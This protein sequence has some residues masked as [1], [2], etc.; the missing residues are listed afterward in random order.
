MRTSCVVGFAFLLVGAS[1]AFAASPQVPLPPMPPHRAPGPQTAA[2]EPAPSPV[3]PA[4]A[5][6][7]GLVAAITLADIGFG[8]G[9][10]FAN[11]GGHRELFVPLPQQANVAASELVLDLDD[12]SAH[13][14][15]RNLEVQVNDRTVTA[16]V[17]DGKTRGRI[18]R[19]P[20]GRTKPKDGYLKLT[21]LYS[22]AATLD[23]C[24]DVRYVGDSLTIRPDT[25]VNVDLGTQAALDVATTA[26]LMP[27]DVAIVLPSR[28]VTASEMA[29]SV[30]VARAL[31]SS[32][33]HVTF[34]HGL[35]AVTDLAK[36]SVPG[37]WTQGIVLVGPLADTVSV[38]DA[39]PTKVAGAFQPLGMLAAAR[40]AGTP[41]LLVSDGDAVRAGRLFSSPL[42]AAT[43]GV[44][45]ATVGDALL[46]DAAADRVTFDQLAVAPAEADVFG[47]A[48]LMAVLDTRRLPPGTRP[49]RLMLD[50]MVA[51]DGADK[52][53][54]VSV[55]VNEQLLG[56]TVAAAGEPT[57]L[58]LLLPPGLFGSI[59][60]VRALVQRDSAQGDCRFEPQG[61][62]AQILGS[63]SLLLEA[64]DG[65]PH[66]F[67]DLTP[68]FGRGFELHL[69]SE[70]ADQPA[71]VLGLVAEVANQLS[72][73][74][75]PVSV[76]FVTAG[77]ADAPDAPFIAVGDAPPPG[78]T[79]RVRFDQ[80]RVAVADRSGRPLLDLGGFSGGAV[81]QIVS[82]GDRPGLWIKSLAADSSLPA[83][84]DLHLDHGDVAFIDG[85]GVALAMS[86]ERDTVVHIAYPDRVS[87]LTVAERF[88]T[89]IIA[90]LWLLA[91]AALLLTLQRVF[92]RRP[93]NG[94]D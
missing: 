55:F 15:R 89:W 74:L 32:G 56:S 8:N 24:I 80:G 85:N 60:N 65:P 86:T 27:R 94:A 9:L 11:L 68:R 28:R 12:L 69:P 1:Q 40:V 14:A 53:A 20:L 88:R 70:A 25:A 30:T 36:S 84:A 6:P 62:P 23:R 76:K 45:A 63:S 81:A 16:I 47:R 35:G 37:Q 71:H 48:D 5:Q 77:I 3:T 26:A 58:D 59:A 75:T 41:A 64:A 67:S 13:D 2:V 22:G 10:R 21:F 61:Y 93:A 66:D 52:K 51:P 72:A 38:T 73:D 78:T 92:R 91:T 31:L 57:H 49:A 83:P 79:P 4:P 34:Y 7:T 87:W 29:T 18:V 19:V 82:A 46:L 33:R 39:P 44:T 90:G 17:L 42:L 54:V 50:V 43:R